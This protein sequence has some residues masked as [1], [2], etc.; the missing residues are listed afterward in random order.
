MDDPGVAPRRVYQ[1]DGTNSVA[2]WAPDGVALIVTNSETPSNN[3]LWLVPLDG[4]DPRL[5]TPHTGD[6]VY[7][8]VEWAPDGQSLYLVTDQEREFAALAR[9][10]LASGAWQPLADRFSMQWSVFWGDRRKRM[11]ILVSKLDH[12]LQDLLWRWR[13]GELQATGVDHLA[14]I[15]VDAR[16]DTVALPVLEALAG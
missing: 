11:V 3:N 9:L 13:I 12:C 7:E 5:L 15:P 10:D 4:G 14:V 8:S 6:A 2:A 16:G 1:Q